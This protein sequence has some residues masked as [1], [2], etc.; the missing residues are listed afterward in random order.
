[1]QSNSLPGSLKQWLDSFINEKSENMEQ[2]TSAFT[3]WFAID[4]FQSTCH[5]WFA[6]IPFSIH[7]V[8]PLHNNLNHNI[9]PHKFAS[10]DITDMA[11][12]HPKPIK[13][14]E[15]MPQLRAR[16]IF[17]FYLAQLTEL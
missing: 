1:V 13:K 12:H 17:S 14:A 9:T 10:Y 2:S 15:Y 11:K 16:E 8:S 7:L 6:P 3:G 5:T 4:R